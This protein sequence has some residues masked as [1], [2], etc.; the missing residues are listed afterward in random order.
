MAD[1]TAAIIIFFLK[2]S[3]DL[4]S[5]KDGLL[6]GLASLRQACHESLLVL[7]PRRGIA[8]NE[9]MDITLRNG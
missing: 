5:L 2:R 1:N 4:A 7:C 8:E 6:L 9:T 3:L